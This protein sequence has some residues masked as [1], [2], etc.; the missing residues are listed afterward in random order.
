MAKINLDKR[1]EHFTLP[2]TI[3]LLEGGTATINFKAKARSRTE[4]SLLQDQVAEAARTRA[5]ELKAD[6][7]ADK[8]PKWSELVGRSI[9]SDSGFIMKLA[10][11][12]DLDD[13]FT[14]ENVMKLIDN[15]GGAAQKIVDGYQAAIIEGRLG[16]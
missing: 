11:G 7:Q 4:L 13:D 8:A 16:N 15:F 12:W 1:V 14:Q 3:N 10:D 5:D 6:A 2:V 9:E